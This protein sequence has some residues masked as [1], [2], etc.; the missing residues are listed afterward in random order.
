VSGLLDH[1][2]RRTDPNTP[3]CDN[4]KKSKAG[5][6]SCQASITEQLF[7]DTNSVLHSRD[8]RQLPEW[9]CYDH[10]VRKTTKHGRVVAVMKN[11]T[12]IDPRWLGNNILK[13]FTI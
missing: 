11:V 2:A 6:F 9:V 5:Y 10:I 8:Y 1:I 3:T 13:H 12:P 7:I 4:P